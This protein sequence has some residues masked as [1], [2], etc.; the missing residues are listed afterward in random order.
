[1]SNLTEGNTKA[2]AQSILYDIL[3]SRY[4]S[5]ESDICKLVQKQVNKV[6]EKWELTFFSGM[7]SYGFHFDNES[8]LCECME[9]NGEFFSRNLHNGHSITDSSIMEQMKESELSELYDDLTALIDFSENLSHETGKNDLSWYLSALVDVE[10]FVYY[11]GF[12]NPNS[13]TK[14]QYF[15]NECLS[16]IADLPNTKK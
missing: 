7:G 13:K 11:N 6:C 16:D 4:N 10:G 8:E 3:I 9:H 5:L 15:T 1:V 12:K 2:T 14:K